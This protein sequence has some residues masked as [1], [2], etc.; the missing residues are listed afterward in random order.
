MAW[1]LLIKKGC[2][3][4]SCQGLPRLHGAQRTSSTSA[5]RVEVAM[6]GSTES[7]LPSGL[8]PKEPPSECPALPV[9]LIAA[10]VN[11]FSDDLFASC[12]HPWAP[13]PGLQL[14][15]PRAWKAG[16]PPVVKTKRLRLPE[17]FGPSPFLVR[18]V[19]SLPD[20]VKRKPL[21]VNPGC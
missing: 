16:G 3:L 4:S 6:E 8:H 21:H 13:A 2:N 18:S 9:T 7:R 10:V 17:C 19:S 12:P 14:G 20:S 11:N 5:D 15:L 1:R